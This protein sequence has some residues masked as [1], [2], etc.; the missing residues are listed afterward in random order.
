MLRV[1][2][3]IRTAVLLACSVPL[4]AWAIPLTVTDPFLQLYHA[5]INS[6]GFSTGSLIRFGATSV[7]PNGNAGTTG[8]ATTVNTSTG[9]NVSRNLTFNPGPVTPNFFTRAINFNPNLLGPWTLHFTN[10]AD[11]SLTTLSLPAG[12][13]ETPFVS[14]ITLSGTAANPTFSWAPPPGTTVNGYRVNIYDRSIMNFDPTKGPINNGQVTSRN[15]Q[16]S[17]TSYMVTNADFT[18]PGYAFTQGTPYTIEISLLQTRDGGSSNLSNNNV[19]ALSRVYADFTPLSS[20][21]P[22]VNLPVVNI[23]GAYEYN[24]AVTPGVTYYLDP[25]IATGY[26]FAIGAGDPNFASVLLPA[27]Q[28]DPYTLSFLDNGVQTIEQLAPGVV[29]DFPTGGVDSFVVTGID[30]AL[31]LDPL[32]TTAFVTGVTF[33]SAGTFTGTQTPIVTTTVP[34]PATLLVL[35]AGTVAAGWAR[36]QRTTTS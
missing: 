28:T 15:L 13:V 11:Q 4:A 29:F 25:D 26:T 2:V 21:P 34:E 16:P 32:N 18:V 1:P 33:V 31:H 20:G 3:V 22:L 6:D 36:R 14:S 9:A 5:G 27:I 10:G 23:N 19:Y 7:V 17:V 35:L 30:A 24:M 8:F 12:A